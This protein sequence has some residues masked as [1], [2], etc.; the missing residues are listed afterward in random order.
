MDVLVFGLTGDPIHAG[1]VESVVHATR[2]L[3][4][5]GRPISQVML[6]PSG[7]QHSFKYGRVANF[8]H[9]HAMCLLGAAEIAKRLNHPSI[10]ITTSKIERYMRLAHPTPVPSYTVETLAVLRETHRLWQNGDG[11]AKPHF[12]LLMGSDLFT[13]SQPLFKHWVGLETVVN[14]AT[15]VISLRPDFPLNPHF[16]MW[17]EARGARIVVLD[18]MSVDTSSGELRNRLGRGED[19]LRLAQEGL[20]PSSVAEYIRRNDLYRWG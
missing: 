12:L 6:I 10:R 2:Q 20:I 1:H 19:P 7:Y 17:L 15:L 13:G 8:E 3:K 5:E 9:R 18:F 4:R 16:L 11:I 14:E